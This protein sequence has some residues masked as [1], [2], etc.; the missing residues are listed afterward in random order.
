MYL[1]R[2]WDERRHLLP[3]KILTPGSIQFNPPRICP[4]LLLRETENQFG[5]TGDLKPL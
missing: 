5:L 1:R 4:S 3:R 2:D